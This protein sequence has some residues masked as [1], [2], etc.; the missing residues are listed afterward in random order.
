MLGSAKQ[1]IIRSRA[2][3][4]A[5]LLLSHSS[6]TIRSVSKETGYHRNTVFRDLTIHLRE[7]DSQLYDL[8]Q[9]R[10][11][12]NSAIKHLRGG[13]ATRKRYSGNSPL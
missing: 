6:G 12:Y 3:K 8:V 11:A 7:A 4:H 2:I 9:S 10:L 1:M 13:E 5:R